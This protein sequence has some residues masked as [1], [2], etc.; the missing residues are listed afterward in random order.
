MNEITAQD[1]QTIR[2]L[3][4]MYRQG[5]VDAAEYLNKQSLHIAHQI[6][7]QYRDLCDES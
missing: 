7:K 2:L 6:K 5:W 3:L 1:I 4:M